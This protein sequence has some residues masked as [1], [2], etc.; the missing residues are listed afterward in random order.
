[1]KNIIQ[2][3]LPLNIKYF[4]VDKKYIPVLDGEGTCCDNCG[5]IIANI[6]TVKNENGGLFIIGFDCMETLLINNKLL[7]Q[8]DIE[9]Y[10][11]TKKMISK[12]IRFSKTIKE[13]LSKHP[14]VTGILFEKST[15][16]TDYQTFY[17]L[18]NNESEGRDNDYVKLKDVSFDFLIETLKNI[19]PYLTILTK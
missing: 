6:A 9:S 2:R 11:K 1:M 7:S 14:F 3:K 19:F 15:Y 16:Q 4:V 8:E 5:K 18:K 10:E 13:V 12:I 17:W